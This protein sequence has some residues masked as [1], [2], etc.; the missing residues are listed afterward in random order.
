MVDVRVLESYEARVLTN[1]AP[2]VFDQPVDARWCEEF[3]ADARHHLAVA[4]D[5]D[6]VVG[7]ASGLHYVHPD[8]PPELWINEVGVAP[9]HEGRGIGKRLLAAL[10]ARGAARGCEEALVL[11]SRTNPAAQRMYQGAGGV[12]TGEQ[13]VMFTF[14]LAEPA[15]AGDVAGGAARA[16]EA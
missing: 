11:T 2:G 5:G 3:F 6:Q 15:A 16:A 8:K 1:V 12:E 10:L 9:T 7:M 13:P 14:R 4:L